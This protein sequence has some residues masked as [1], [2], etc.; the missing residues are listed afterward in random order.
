MKK[1]FTYF[2]ITLTMSL[3]STFSAHAEKVVCEGPAVN[4]S[5]QGQ[6][7]VILGKWGER[8]ILV[9]LWQEGG[10]SGFNTYSPDLYSAQLTNPYAEWTATSNGVYTDKGDGGFL[11]EGTFTDGTTTYELTMTNVETYNNEYVV[12]DLLIT[13]NGESSTTFQGSADYINFDF[14]IFAVGYGTHEIEGFIGQMK[15]TGTAVF[16]YSE[17]YKSDLLVASLNVPQMGWKVKVTMYT[18]YIEPTDTIVCE[19][20]EKKISTRGWS[21]TLTLSGQHEEYGKVSFTIQGCDGTYN[22]Y[23][24]ITGKVGNIDVIGN[25]TWS[26]DGNNDV[27]EAILATEDTTQV[28]HVWAYTKAEVQKEPI[29]VVV[30]NA[31]FAEGEEESDEE[32]SLLINGTSTDGKVV[33]LELMNFNEI[34]IGTYPTNSLSGTIDGVEVA[35]LTK[36]ASLSIDDTEIALEADMEDA[37]GNIYEIVIYGESPNK[38]D[39]IQVIATNL[40]AEVSYGTYLKLTA[41]T[42][43][44]VA[45]EL[46]L[47]EGANRGYDEYG[48]D[49]IY[50]DVE[51]A[52]YG[53]ITLTLSKEVTAKYYPL[54]DIDVFEGTFTGSDNNIYQLKLS[55][56]ALPSGIEDVT[57]TTV[58][59]KIID[60]GQLIILKNGV[61]YNATGGIVK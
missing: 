6:N 20:M 24:T 16:S 15:A 44:G 8:Q 51:N 55:S 4:T 3:L 31:T 52:K 26:N 34:G 22:K 30:N 59:E 49:G 33:A 23:P 11:F 12:Q 9:M 45:I 14:T 47:Y 50:P 17:E 19:N 61:K 32:G 38:Q 1:I 25:G 29:K 54:G 57:T 48:Y 35:N 13:V 10:V 60:N 56:A 46:S 39:T 37:E 53:K 21:P 41:T 7:I 27:L 42:K 58:I 18:L 2:L 28:F 5:V 43:E 40:K 36:S